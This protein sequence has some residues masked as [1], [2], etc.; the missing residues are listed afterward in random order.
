MLLGCIMANEHKAKDIAVEFKRCYFFV[1]CICNT[2]VKKA[3]H[4]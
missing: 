1:I 2:H 3:N 4:I